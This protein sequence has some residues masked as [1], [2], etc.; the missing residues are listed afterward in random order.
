MENCVSFKKDF[1]KNQD[2][3]KYKSNLKYI[4]RKPDEKNLKIE[5]IKV[6][7]LK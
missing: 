3:L 1:V 7:L 2:C 5:L 6:Y 4:W